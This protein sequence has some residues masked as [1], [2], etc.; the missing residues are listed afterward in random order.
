MFK[1]PLSYR[2]EN[3]PADVKYPEVVAY[4]LNLIE[5]KQLTPTIIWVMGFG[6]TEFL[7]DLYTVC[8]SNKVFATYPA[9]KPN[10]EMHDFTS[11]KNG[12]TVYF[13][14]EF[15]SPFLFHP[16]RISYFQ[17]ILRTP[18]NGD[19]EI[20][21]LQNPVFLLNFESL[22]NQFVFEIPNIEQLKN[23]N[24]FNEGKL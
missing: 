22:S 18:G 16:L 5:A 20:I 11:T 1:Y 23:I 3:F 12:P 8:Q 19:Q 4:F 9:D 2:P 7:H 17:H 21:A 14:D 24:L 10:I 13:K 6:K 15:A